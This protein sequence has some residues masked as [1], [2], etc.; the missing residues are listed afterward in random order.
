MIPKEES[1]NVVNAIYGMFKVMTGQAMRTLDNQI[2]KKVP[3]L[4]MIV[5]SQLYHISKII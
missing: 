3:K 4:G 1:K 2:Q 5:E